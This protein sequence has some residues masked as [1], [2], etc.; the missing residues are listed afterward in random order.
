[1]KILFNNKF[2]NHNQNSSVEGSYRLKDFS[3]K[4]DNSDANGEEFITL[5]HSEEYKNL[6][7]ESCLQG[8]SMAEDE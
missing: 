4:Y 3:S 8:N 2:L 5:V 1:M 7:K 6:I